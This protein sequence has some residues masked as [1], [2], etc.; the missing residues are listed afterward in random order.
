MI[1][2]M[3]IILVKGYRKFAG[4]NENTKKHLKTVRDLKLVGQKLMMC[5]LII[6]ILFTFN[7]IQRLLF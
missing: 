1:I 4:D 2:L 5:L 7:C 3:Y 6:L